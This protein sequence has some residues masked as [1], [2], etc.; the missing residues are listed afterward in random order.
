MHYFTEIRGT[1]WKLHPEENILYASSASLWGNG[2]TQ[3]YPKNQWQSQKQNC[4]PQ[5]PKSTIPVL[6]PPII[7]SQKYLQLWTGK[8]SNPSCLPS[9][10]PFAEDYPNLPAEL[11]IRLLPNLC[12]AEPYKLAK[13][14]TAE[15]APSYFNPLLPLQTVSVSHDFLTHLK[16][17]IINDS[18]YNSHFGGNLFRKND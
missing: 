7:S 2:P 5:E 4:Q 1:Q 3:K 15:T 14:I 9:S 8:G 18:K 16:N 6:F 10:S 17:G 12:L 11:L 13:V